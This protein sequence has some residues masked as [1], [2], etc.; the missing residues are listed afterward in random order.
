QPPEVIKPYIGFPLEQMYPDFTEAPYQELYA[1]FKVKAAETVVASTTALPHVEELLAQLHETDFKL[2]V[3]TTKIKVHVDGIVEKLGWQNYFDV[4][5]GGDEAVRF[6]PD[7]AI[8]HIALKRLNA[9][10]SESMVVGDTIN[11]VLAARAV[12]MAVTAVASPYGKSDQ[13][14]ASRPDHYIEDIRQLPQLLGL[15][16]NKGG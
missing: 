14:V 10:P 5:V 12:P 6:K 16:Q 15:D 7:P 2:A 1:H 11:D 3:A 9:H 8:F 13:L 4:S